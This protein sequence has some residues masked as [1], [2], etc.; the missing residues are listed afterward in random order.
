MGEGKRN[1]GEVIK[2]SLIKLEEIIDLFDNTQEVINFLAEHFSCNKNHDVQ[3]FLLNPNKAIRFEK[4][5][6][7][8]TYFI[9]NNESSNGEILAY[10]TV[11]FKGVTVSEHHKLSKSVMKKLNLNERNNNVQTYL[12]GQIAKNEKVLANPI[13]LNDILIET[14]SIIVEAQNL[15]GG[16]VIILECENQEKLIQLYKNNGFQPLDTIN[17]LNEDLVTMFTTIKH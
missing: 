7:A 11:S 15:V 16:R 2:T 4:S 5:F 8:R 10:F 3:N 6:K 12:I 9:L 13:I 17:N 14:N 1:R